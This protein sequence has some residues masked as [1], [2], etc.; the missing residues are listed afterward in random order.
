MNFLRQIFWKLSSDEWAYIDTDRQTESIEIINHVALRVVNYGNSWNHV[1]VQFF[2]QIPY[3]LFESYVHRVAADK[4][5]NF[6]KMAASSVERY[7]RTVCG[8]KYVANKTYRS[9]TN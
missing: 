1:S 2:I 4:L 6:T 8:R 7:W 5:V 3:R 9:K